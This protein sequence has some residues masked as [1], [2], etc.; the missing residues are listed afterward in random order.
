MPF[1]DQLSPDGVA[2]PQYESAAPVTYVAL[3]GVWHDKKRGKR[4]VTP[5]EDRGIRSAE[6]NAPS[7]DRRR[8]EKRPQRYEL[9]KTF[10]DHQEAEAFAKGRHDAFLEEQAYK[11][12]KSELLSRLNRGGV[13]FSTISVVDEVAVEIFLKFNLPTLIIRKKSVALSEEYKMLVLQMKKRNDLLWLKN[14]DVPM[15]R[16]AEAAYELEVSLSE[17]FEAGF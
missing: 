2:D 7:S 11:S 14:I 3:W 15:L 5:Y 8:L 10:E 13:L 16:L 1:Y 12:K 4:L 9:I 6:Y 17:A